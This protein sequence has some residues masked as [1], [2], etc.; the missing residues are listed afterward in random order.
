MSICQRCGDR[1][2][3]Q[4][5]AQGQATPASEPGPG[6][7]RRRWERR[8]RQARKEHDAVCFPEGQCAFPRDRVAPLRGCA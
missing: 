7:R 8:Q 4:G 2:V 1:G 5:A 6:A 3:G